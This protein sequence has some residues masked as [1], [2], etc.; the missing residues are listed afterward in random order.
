[1]RLPSLWSGR[2]MLDPFRAMQRDI[3]SLFSDY[4]KDWTKGMRMP[5]INVGESDGEIDITVEL[6]G[7]DQKDIKLNIEGNRLTISGEKREET[8]KDEKDWHVVERSYGS[9]HRAVALP[10]EPASDAVEAHFDNGV[11]RLRVKKPATAKAQQQTIEIKSGAPAQ[12]PT[13]A[14]NTQ[15]TPQDKTG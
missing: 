7:V 5:A 14:A 10:F 12:Q 13:S 15:S 6:P 1:M 2:D 4:S 8:K 3:D 9:F 11:L